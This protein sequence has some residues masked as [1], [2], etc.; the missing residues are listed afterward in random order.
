[1]TDDELEALRRVVLELVANSKDR[2]YGADR[3]DA[4]MKILRGE[5]EKKQD[6][7]DFEAMREWCQSLGGDANSCPGKII[8]LL[9]AVGRV[10]KELGDRGEFGLGCISTRCRELAAELRG[11]GGSNG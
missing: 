10:A 2:S 11:T 1:M 5:P 7:F 9:S 3:F 6:G 8:A 4:D